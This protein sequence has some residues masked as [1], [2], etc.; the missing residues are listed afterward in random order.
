MLTLKLLEYKE[1]FIVINQKV[2][3][4]IW[5]QVKPDEMAHVPQTI[6]PASD[7]WTWW[8]LAKIATII[9]PSCLLKGEE[10]Y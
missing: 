5:H 6:D 7:L 9:I 10:R 1:W 2:P 4:T 8:Q 3:L